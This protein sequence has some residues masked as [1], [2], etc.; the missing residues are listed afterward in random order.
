MSEPQRFRTPLPRPR[1]QPSPLFPEPFAA[2]PRDCTFVPLFVLQ[3]LA[4]FVQ[5]DKSLRR[6]TAYEYSF[7]K[8]GTNAFLEAVA[9][10]KI[11]MVKIK[12]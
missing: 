4:D 10:N 3:V 12:I 5:H 8:E 1:V 2:T 9:E 7:S 11:L 6:L